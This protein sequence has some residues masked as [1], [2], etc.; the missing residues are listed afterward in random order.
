MAAQL[1]RSE[2]SVTFRLTMLAVQLHLGGYSIQDIEKATFQSPVTLMA[3]LT[4]RTMPTAMS[5][6]SDEIN[7]ELRESSQN[8]KKAEAKA[9]VAMPCLNPVALTNQ[10]IDAFVKDQI[11]MLREMVAMKKELARLT[12]L[13]E[14][15][16][17]T[18]G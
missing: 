1:G 7:S 11:T 15:A 17:G 16:P 8:E 13:L 12:A 4:P 9:K 5:E 2:Q 18:T 6:G 14:A 10:R 3:W